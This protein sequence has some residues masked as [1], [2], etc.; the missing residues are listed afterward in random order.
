MT[1]SNSS[2][3]NDN[4]PDQDILSPHMLQ[5]LAATPVIIYQSLISQSADVQFVSPNA[6]AI[7]DY[8]PENFEVDPS[9]LNQQINSLDRAA[10]E[11][12]VRD[13][14]T[15]ETTSVEYRL[16]NGKGDWIWFRD[17]LAIVKSMKISA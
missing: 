5:L 4:M 12:A 15:N 6:G 8:D 7:L 3:V 10:Y 17:Q 13:L 9:W 1:S 14:A 11:A 16:Q 2:D